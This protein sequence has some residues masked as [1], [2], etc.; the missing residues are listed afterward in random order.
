MSPTPKKSELEELQLLQRSPEM[1]PDF[2]CPLKF[3][4]QGR[5][6]RGLPN[7]FPSTIITELQQGEC[8]DLLS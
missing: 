4:D 2:E 3:L 6:G 5:I 7:R 8:G 1:A